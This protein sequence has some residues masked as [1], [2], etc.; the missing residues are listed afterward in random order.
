VLVRRYSGD[1][2]H[3]YGSYVAIP[4]AD[5]GCCSSPDHVKPVRY[6]A[7]ELQGLLGLQQMTSYDAGIGHTCLDRIAPLQ[8]KGMIAV[9]CR[10]PVV[11]QFGSAN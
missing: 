6:D 1:H 2:P 11:V 10:A 7:G 5:A 3:H 9:A 8:R 4:K